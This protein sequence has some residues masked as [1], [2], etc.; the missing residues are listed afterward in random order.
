[1][2][3]LRIRSLSAYA[4]GVWMYHSSALQ[5]GCGILQEMTDAQKKELIEALKM[6]DKAK[7]QIERLLK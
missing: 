6:I 4:I 5:Y 3:T 2:P 1:M 7:R